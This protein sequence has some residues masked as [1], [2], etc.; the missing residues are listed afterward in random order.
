[1]KKQ[2][3]KQIDLV[4]LGTVI[5]ILMIGILTIYSASSFSGAEKYGN[6]LLY[7][8][9]HLSRIFMGFVGLWILMHVD[10][11]HIRWI[12]PFMLF[13]FFILL[14][15]VLRLEKFHGTNRF[16]LLFGKRFQPSEFMK[17]SLIF[18]LAAVFT[19][20]KEAQIFKGKRLYIH[21]VFVL[22]IMGLVFI[23]PDLGSALVLFF[24]V[25]MMFYIGGVPGRQLLRMG[26]F[27][28]P[29]IGIGMMKFPYQRRRVVDFLSG[30][31]GEA[32]VS[33][34]VKQSII[35]LANG[36]IFG[37]GYGEGKQKLLFLPEP[38]SD[39][40]LSSLGEEW[41]FIGLTL[42]FGLMIIILW[43]GVRIAMHAPDRYGYL[44]AGGITSMILINALINA[45]VAVNLLPTTGLPFPFVSYGGSSLLVH[46]LGI[47]I[48]LNISRNRVVLFHQFTAQRGKRGLLNNEL[49]EHY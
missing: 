43:R 13:S 21:Y 28:F 19:K 5:I 9:K 38:F 6:S 24:I 11:H 8:K 37:V 2:D 34:Q 32:P 1:M 40:I 35:G 44:M 16:L 4:L 26:W 41:G 22:I 7:L 20:G 31:I 45:G 12:T 18:Y 36:G 15:M 33:Y 29:F 39:F 27:L 3:T 42:L 10:Y 30:V 25:F 48:L 49:V 47:G 23:E 46:L 14:I 17:L